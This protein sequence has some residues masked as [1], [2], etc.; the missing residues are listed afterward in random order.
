M[1]LTADLTGSFLRTYTTLF[2]HPISH[3][4]GWRDVHALLRKLGH[5]HEEPNGNLKVTRN[6]HSLVLHPSLTKDVD[7][8]DE[9]MALR[10]FIEGSET[11]D[12]VV[13]IGPDFD[14]HGRPVDHTSHRLLVIDH[15]EA[16]LFRTE[17]K[18]GALERL[19]PHEPSEYFRHEHNSLGFSRGKEKPEPNSFFEPVAEALQGTGEILVFGTGTGKSNEMDQFNAWVK[20]HHPE[21][22][23]RIIGSVVVD[24]HHLTEAQLLA[25]ARACYGNHTRKER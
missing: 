18:D 3:N 19:L 22:S 6:G 15:H 14:I 11:P 17:L 1:T 21:V 10:K 8:P 4:L 2:Q 12:P 25:T 24:E 16:R 5:I 9:I 13:T 20:V 7:T 23:K